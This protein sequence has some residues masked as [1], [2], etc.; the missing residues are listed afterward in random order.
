MSAKQ[1]VSKTVSQQKKFPLKIVVVLCVSVALSILFF[2]NYSR[3]FDHKIDMNGDNIQYYSLG[4]SLS[5]GNGFTNTMG[6]EERPHT[7]FPPGYPLFISFIMKLGFDDIVSVKMANGFLSFISIFLLCYFLYLI[8]RKWLIAIVSAAFFASHPVILR[9][10]TIMMSESLFIIIS[11]IIFIIIMKWDVTKAFREKKKYWKDTLF[12]FSLIA[13]MSYVY[14]IRT[15]AL[16]LIFAVIFYYAIILLIDFFKWIKLKKQNSEEQNLPERKRGFLKQGLLL[17]LLILSFLIPKFAWDARN[18]S[19]NKTQ[20]AYVDAFFMK[21]GGEKMTTFDDW[22]TRVTNNAVAYTTKWVPT[23]VFGTYPDANQKS[24]AGDWIKGILI[25]GLFIIALLRLSK[26]G[27]LLFLYLGITMAVML[28]WPEMY[29]SHRYITPI[30]PFLMF[31]F[32]YGFYIVIQ[33]L[34]SRTIKPKNAKNWQKFIAVASCLVFTIM[35]YPSYAKT[36]KATETQ[37]KPKDYIAG[38]TT[39]ALVEY[40][41]AIRWVKANTIDSTR[42]STRKPELF[43]IYSGGRKSA[44]FPQYATPEEVITHFTNNEINYVII[45]RWFRHAYVTVIPAVQKYQD[46]FKIVH[47]INA[48]EKDMPPTYVLEFNPEWGYTGEMVDD[49]RQGKGKFVM[50]D[51]RVYTG[52]FANNMFNGR[53]TL[54]DANGNILMK[55]IW[56]DN[57]LVKPE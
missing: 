16:S 55:G 15:M 31:L 30:I 12:L 36:M 6:F 26:G 2:S 33:W 53:G 3:T 43:Y 57:A 22:K 23:A 5:E 19:I 40:L 18:N 21:P 9:Y 46:K 10:S 35:A 34:V 52:D 50:Q 11:L 44:L 7:H 17:T 38:T 14:F 39:P 42:V 28:V 49:I 51:G 8:S 41:D 1:P 56:K 45:D 20:D 47:Q 29:T 27:L 25:I 54:T 24:T 48:L 32:I 13:C 37:A 4:K